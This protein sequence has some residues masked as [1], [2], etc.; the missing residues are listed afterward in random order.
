MPEYIQVDLGEEEARSL[1]QQLDVDRDGALGAEDLLRG[2][3][4]LGGQ[5]RVNCCCTYSQN[6]ESF[7]V[8][9][10]RVDKKMGA[11][12]AYIIVS[13]ERV[14]NVA[15]SPLYRVPRKRLLSEWFL[16]GCLPS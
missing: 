15:I 4:T 16:S 9:D 5:W 7:P 13:L 12:V 6:A 11:E 2:G 3:P 1:Y 10:R 8:S 14:G